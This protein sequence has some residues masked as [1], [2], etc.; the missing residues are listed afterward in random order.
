MAACELVSNSVLLEVG[1]PSAVEGKAF[2]AFWYRERRASSCFTIWSVF[3]DFVGASLHEAAGVGKGCSNRGAATNPI[4]VGEQMIFSESP[5]ENRIP[6]KGDRV[7]TP[8]LPDMF[9]VLNVYDSPSRVVDLKLIRPAEHVE[10]QIP[11]EY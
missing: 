4:P 3:I 6:E 7:T 8:G 10:K 9:T 2:N 5:Q 1:R 11:W